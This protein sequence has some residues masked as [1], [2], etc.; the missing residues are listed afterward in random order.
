LSHI[1]KIE[2]EINSL[3]DLKAACLRLGFTFKENQKTYAWYGRF[4]GDSPL[5]EGINQ[6][7]LGQC[8]HVI[9]VPECSYE[10][11]V[12][13]KGLKYILLWD[14]W[15][16]GGLEQKIGKEAGILKQTYT[17]ERIKREA[18]HK[19]YQIKEIQKD[20]SIRLVLR[21]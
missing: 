17:I 21:V 7:D 12:V 20:Q 9:Q 1:S 3:E 19:K 18:K 5:P 15:Y 13:K 6:E 2:L 14:S 11:G 16:R 8:D 10:V 4:V